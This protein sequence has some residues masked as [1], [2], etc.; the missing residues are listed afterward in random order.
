LPINV[1]NRLRGVDVSVLY[2]K[3]QRCSG[4]FLD[5]LS[6][7]VRDKRRRPFSLLNTSCASHS[8]SPSET[9][10]IEWIKERAF[11]HKIEENRPQSAPFGRHLR[12]LSRR[13][14]V[15]HRLVPGAHR[16]VAILVD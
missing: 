12:E 4:C 7:G 1:D 2:P 3:R 10:S 6:L 13:P 15:G 5:F 11:I 14:L 9:G 8:Q 16:Q